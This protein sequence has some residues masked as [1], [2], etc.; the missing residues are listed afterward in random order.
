[1]WGEKQVLD[2]LISWG[3][4]EWGKTYFHK[5]GSH[6][7]LCSNQCIQH[8]WGGYTKISQLLATKAPYWYLL[9]QG[10]L[11]DQCLLALWALPTPMFPFI[12]PAK[13]IWGGRV[14]ARA[15]TWSDGLSR[16]YGC[17]DLLVVL[18]LSEPHNY[19]SCTDTFLHLG[20]SLWWPPWRALVR[21]HHIWGEP[22]LATYVPTSNSGQGK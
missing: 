16:P 19:R 15:P 13:S 8:F 10:W 7:C 4:G 5:G 17:M 18:V 2:N 12:N 3:C 6:H 21:Q 22:A 1:M 14:E 9:C 20:L 11:G